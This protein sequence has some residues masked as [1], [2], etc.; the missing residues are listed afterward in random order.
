MVYLLAI[1][2]VRELKSVEQRLGQCFEVQLNQALRVI[3][4]GL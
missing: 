2:F 1:V 4:R 3:F